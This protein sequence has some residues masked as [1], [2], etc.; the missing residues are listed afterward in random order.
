[1][2]LME[3]EDMWHASQ[4]YKYC[5]IDMPHDEYKIK[6]DYYK[7]VRIYDLYG[8]EQ[9]GRFVQHCP[10]I[11]HLLDTYVPCKKE[12]NLQCTMFCHKYSRDKGCTLNAIE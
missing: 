4:D 10:H 9:F 8:C 2:I 12:K 7:A 6:R 5:P 3:M 1:M 11:E